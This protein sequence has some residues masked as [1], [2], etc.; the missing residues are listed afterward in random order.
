MKRT[1]FA[2]LTAVLLISLGACGRQSQKKADGEITIA[3]ANLSDTFEFCQSVR[4]GFEEECA[5]RGWKIVTMDNKL[6]GTVSIANANNVVSLGV[7]LFVE[8]NPDSTVGEAIMNIMNAAGIP[9]IAIDIPLPGAP[10]FGANNFKAGEVGGVTLAEIGMKEFGADIDSLVIISRPDGGELIIERQDG[11][12]AGVKTLYPGLPDNKIVILDGRGDVLPSQEAFTSFLSANPGARRILVGAVN[13]QCAQ[14]AL[15]AAEI[16][17]RQDHI[18]IIS[19]GCD[20]SALD[21]LYLHGKNAW[22]GSV[23]YA[24][25][26][27]G[28]YAMPTVELMLKKES[29]PM[30]TYVEHFTVTIDNVNQI[31]PR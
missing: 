7:D 2:V 29:F 11:I 19:Q 20:T 12:I 13:D 17:N 14:G 1:L 5:K 27:Y 15:A 24:P 6:D 8:F 4:R 26:N 9:T 25:E 30:F 21:N 18:L 16:A 28:K 10:Y 31:Y 3:F 22:R 23:S